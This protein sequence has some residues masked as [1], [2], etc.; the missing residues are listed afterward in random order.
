MIKKLISTALAVGIF[1]TFTVLP[2]NAQA[3]GEIVKIYVSPTGSDVSDGSFERPLETFEGAKKKVRE[4]RDGEK[5]ATIEVIFR[6][7]VYR[8]SKMVDMTEADSGT[9]NGSVT[10]KAY[11][12]EKPVFTGSI[13]L[14]IKDFKPVSDMEMYERFPSKSRDFIGELNLK[15]YGITSVP[16]FPNGSQGATGMN[17]YQLFLDDE[18]QTLAR[19]PDTGYQKMEKLVDSANR[20][21]MP[22][23]TDI[24]RWGTA[25]PSEI[26]FCGFIKNQYAFDRWML[27]A[28][29]VSDRTMQIGN[30][31]I[32]GNERR[33]YLENFA[34]ELS[35]PGEWYINPETM[36]LY[37][38][39]ERK[40]S[41]ETL[42]ISTMTNVMVRMRNVSYV[43]F[44]GLTFAKT[45][46]NVLST[47]GCH[48]IS[49]TN[50]TFDNIGKSGLIDEDTSNAKYHYDLL[51]NK[52][53]S[54]FTID[55][56]IFTDLGAG[57]VAVVGGDR[58][59]LEPSG[60]KI[61]NNYFARYA[62]DWKNY[63]PAID[64]TGVAI[65]AYNNTIHDSPGNAIQ[66]Y[67]NDHK[68]MYNEIYE[69]MKDVHDAGA[70]YEGRS[71]ARRGTEIAYN[72]FHTFKNT[73]P[74][75][76][77]T[78]VGVYMDDGLCEWNVHHNV[79]E[80]ISRAMLCGGDYINVENNIFYNCGTSIRLGYWKAQ[81][82]AMDDFKEFVNY[83]AYDKYTT[84][85]G[86]TLE[87]YNYG[88]NIRKNVFIASPVDIDPGALTEEGGSVCEDNIETNNV[89]EI[90]FKNYKEKNFEISENSKTAKEN[91]ELL[92]IDMSKIG[93]S[94][95]MWAKVQ[96]NEFYKI[97][98]ENGAENINSSKVTFRWHYNDL[99]DRFKFI[100]ATDPEMKN[101]I[102]EEITRYNN[103]T[104]EDVLESGEK[105]YYWNVTGLDSSKNNFENKQSFGSVYMLETSKYEDV[106]KVLLSDEIADAEKIMAELSI[107]TEYGQCSEEAYREYEIAIAD[108]KKVNKTKLT[109]QKVIDRATESLSIATMKINAE[110]IVG[111]ENLAVPLQNSKWTSQASDSYVENGTLYVKDK[112]ACLDEIIPGYKVL[113]FK[114]KPDKDFTMIAVTIRLPS[115]GII[116]QGGAGSNGYTLIMKPNLIEYQRYKQGKGGI[117][118]T[119]DNQWLKG[120]E[121]N[122]IEVGCVPYENGLKTIL[123]INGE[124]VL[125]EYDDSGI[126]NEEGSIQFEN[127]NF[128]KGLV[129]EVKGAEE[130]PE[131]SESIITGKLDEVIPEFVQG[132][133]GYSKSEDGDTE[134][135]T[136]LK[137]NEVINTDMTF[138]GQEISLRSDGED[139][140]RVKISAE[141]IE[142]IRRANGKDMHIVYDENTVI[143]M[144]TKVNVTFGAYPLEEGMRILMY[145]NGKKVF[146]YV[147]SY[148][149]HK[150]TDIKVYKNGKGTAF[151]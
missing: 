40:L 149:K 41:N 74:S 52:L 60:T 136:G 25:K 62:L 108:A 17:Y 75:I 122:D 142:L 135:L 127:F 47:K 120:G 5:D 104:L 13:E 125:N 1:S 73:D 87:K 54:H 27:K 83:P 24:T 8:M 28:I 151:N 66:P 44:E 22:G 97:Y 81:Q 143:S 70:I 105:I 39:P 117:L 57:C 134:T 37:Y 137:G 67:G 9:K 138:N 77:N 102:H 20:I 29:N 144:N 132:I 150:G 148:S 100:L 98:P 78:V 21:F 61:T 88:N 11:E 103:I 91:P 131:F 4:V 10:Y 93:I 99:Y 33:F 121:W 56:N 79:F 113:A 53:S 19:W 89:D 140:Y 64:M 112:F 12:G 6:G 118:K 35:T 30:S 69:V 31:T 123:R 49:I 45:S 119:V 86:A 80:D 145:A 106:N 55:S 32:N 141:K 48:Y 51:T 111:Y 34:E 94:E 129:L 76:G 15:D 139:E 59:T 85:N 126:I 65:E 68:I 43:N 38:Y 92:K 3:K 7:G 84:E 2:Q 147:D 128:D 16:G 133:E 115:A 23:G 18:R 116:W 146:D 26:H 46:G 107:G 101:V 109:T 82:Q 71:K 50:C 95:E 36:M 63:A 90:E 124:E 72:Y 114:M 58:I 96:N 130:L 110:R 14:D 42:E